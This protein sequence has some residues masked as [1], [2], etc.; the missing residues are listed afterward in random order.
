MPVG[1]GRHRRDERLLARSGD[2]DMENK[3]IPIRGT[4]KLPSMRCIL[5]ND[6][7]LCDHLLSCRSAETFSVRG[8]VY[9]TALL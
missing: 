5:P 1:Q 8:E 4:R 2:R 7:G 3:T 6:L 9:A